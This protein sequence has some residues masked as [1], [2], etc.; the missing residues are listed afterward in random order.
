MDGRRC[1]YQNRSDVGFR[2]TAYHLPARCNDSS[3]GKTCTAFE[4]VA[5][6]RQ[7]HGFCEDERDSNVQVTGCSVFLED[8]EQNVTFS[9]PY[10]EATI[11]SL[12]SFIS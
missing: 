7:V 4:R 5:A 11:N 12:F 8:R 6:Q 3:V 9:Q 10:E 2:E 1:G